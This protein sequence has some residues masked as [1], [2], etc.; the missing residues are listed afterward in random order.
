MEEGGVWCS[1]LEEEGYCLGW[2]V[3][4]RLRCSCCFG[5]PAVAIAYASTDVALPLLPLALPQELEENEEYVEAEDEFDVNERP[6]PA[7]GAAA[8]ELQLGLAPRDET[9]PVDIMSREVVRVFSSDE[10]DEAEGREAPLHHL[11]VVSGVFASGGGGVRWVWVCEC[12]WE[13]GVGWAE[14]EALEGRTCV[15]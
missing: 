14:R 9:L 3:L 11:P 12:V 5:T 6:P 10:E 7:D 1:W 8:P 2:A 13:G 4:A 15:V